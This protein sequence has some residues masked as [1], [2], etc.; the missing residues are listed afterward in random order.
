MYCSEGG[1]EVA[2]GG[3]KLIRISISSLPVFLPARSYS[4]ITAKVKIRY[5]TSEKGRKIR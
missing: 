2:K 5:P 4:D 3:P 1:L